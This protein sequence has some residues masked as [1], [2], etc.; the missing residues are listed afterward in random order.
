MA[1]GVKTRNAKAPNTPTND[2]LCLAQGTK[3]TRQLDEPCIASKISR[4]VTPAFFEA[5]GEPVEVL[6]V[7]EIGRERSRVVDARDYSRL[8]IYQ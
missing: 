5:N 4:L 8:N 3:F 1:I 7:R 6:F 2:S